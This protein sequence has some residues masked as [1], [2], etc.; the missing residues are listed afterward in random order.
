MKPCYG[1]MDPN[2]LYFVLVSVHGL[3]RGHDLELGRD[4]DTGGQTLYVVELARALAALPEVGRVDLMTRRVVDPLVSR[5]YAEPLESLGPKARIVRIDAGPDGYIRKEELWD[6]LDSFADNALAFLRANGPAPSLVHSHYAD[7]GYVGRRL[8]SLFGVPLVHTGHSLGRVKRSRLLASGLARDLIETRYHMARRVEA[9][10]LTLGTASLVIASTHNEIEEQYGL[11]EQYQ[12][13]Y[14]RVI[15]PGTDLDRFTPPDGVERSAPI[16][17]ELARFLADPTK[18][19]ILAISRPDERKNIATLVQAYGESPELQALANLVVVAGNRDDIRDLDTGARNVLADLL[20]DIDRYDLY[21][22]VAYPKH[23]QRED[24]AMLYR[25]AAAGRGVFVNPALT[26]PFGLT[27]IE[28]AACGLPLVATSDGGPRDI[29]GNCRNGYLVDPLDAAEMAQALLTVLRD[30]VVWE[31]FSQAGIEG[32]VRHYSWH[33]HAESYLEAVRPLLEQARPVRPHPPLA[34]NPMLYHDRAIFTTLDRTLL[35]DRESLAEFVET[36]RRHRKLASFGI[37]TA[38]SLVS[39]LK[40]MRKYGIPVPDVLIT[41][42]GSEIYYA[43]E[44]EKD[45][46]WKQHIDHLWTR[47]AVRA[48]LD[49]VPGLRYLPKSEQGRFNVSY[50]YDPQEAPPLQDIHSLLR[51]TE[52]TVNATL[53]YGTRLDVVPVRASKGFAVRWCADRWGIPLERILVAGGSGADEDMMRGNTLAV[54]V[55]NRRH[56]ELITTLA[57][58]ERVYFA[59]AGHAKGILEAMEYYD[60]Y[61][62]CA[63]PGPVDG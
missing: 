20:L 46:V 39:A 57:N 37:A 53:S 26:E 50:Q 24:V 34:H 33:A 52:Q 2:P 31:G 49:E 60:F 43:P 12:P 15:P 22:R 45:R 21:G 59:R 36:I 42:M 29:I 55:E 41:G 25:L 11:Y 6:H 9:E 5:D 16:A 17:L 1:E 23:H 14:M 8:A 30:G 7:A 47:D 44:L 32:V 10:E 63:A 19:M 27:L 40:V 58:V 18:P 56:D 35:G 4:A 51:Q 3:I 61:G 48:A 13:Q 38:R 62:A 54:V 28:A